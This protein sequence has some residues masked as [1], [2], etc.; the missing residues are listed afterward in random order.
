MDTAIQ[1]GHVPP[2][3]C[4]I[5][6]LP[7]SRRFDI[8]RKVVVDT[9]ESGEASKAAGGRLPA[10]M[11]QTLAKVAIVVALC[12]SCPPPALAAMAQ[13]PLAFNIPGGPLSN[14]LIEIGKRSGAIVSFSP[15]LVEGEAAAPVQ[16]DFTPMQAFMRALSASSLS[17]DVTPNGT[18]TV[19]PNQAAKPATKTTT[20]RPASAV[21]EIPPTEDPPQDPPRYT[22]D[23]VLVLASAGASHA[24]GLRASTAS[25]ATRTDTPLLELPQSV[26]V[27]TRDALDLHGPNVT[28]TDALRYVTGV[29][30]ESEGMVPSL[31]VRGLP[32]QY[33]LSGMGSLRGGLSIDSA[34]VERI[35]VLKGP[36]GVIGGVADFGGRGGIVNLVR[37]SI[38]TQ[39]YAE[40]KQGFTSRDGGTLRTDLEAAGEVAPRTYWRTVAYGSRSGHTDGGYASQQATG[41]LGLLGYRGADVNATLTLQTDNRRIAPE[42]ISRGGMQRADGSFTAIEPS[43][44]GAIDATDGMRWR[45]TDIELDLSWQLSPQWRMTWKGRRESLDSDM[46]QHLYWAFD[47]EAGVDLARHQTDARGASMQWG[48]I[49]NFATGPMSHRL[50]MAFDLDHW[51]SQIGDESASWDVDPATF[52]PGVTPLPATPTDDSSQ[53]TR[54][55]KRAVLLQDQVRLGNW[56]ARLAAQRG[57][58]SESTDFDG[59][60]L[61]EPKFTNWE[62][63]LLYQITPTVSVYAGTQYSV[64]VDVEGGDYLLYDGT[65]APLRKLRQTQ[66]GTKLELLERRLALTL[67][68]FRL[69]QLT[70]LKSSSELP[71]SGLFAL[72]GRSSTGVEAELSGR[73]SP[74][75][76]MHLGLNL[77]RARDAVPGPDSA[78][79]QSVESPAT[80]I[81][82][83]SLHLLARYR[84]PATEPVH[85]SVGLAF[86]AYSSSWVVP[87]DPS[88][89]PSGLRLPGG[90]QF[91]LS[92]TR[93]AER[94]A[95]RVSIKNLFDRQLYGTQST[96]GYIPLQPRRS[97]GLTATFMN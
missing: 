53:T 72:P 95:L 32:A 58:S 50:L 70:T 20:E 86:R 77:I 80:G 12:G 1:A 7:S 31:M 4:T 8:Q 73:V 3:V 35:E 97:V 42:P 89:G 48:L 51:R 66:A 26:S 56:I 10:P 44:V 21:Y 29:T 64:E 65:A 43:Q 45:S 5:D 82:E 9:H 68:A 93:E 76:D 16:G 27:V 78:P 54:K 17:I 94:L 6:A 28:T 55:R 90:A 84:L 67:E 75:L 71:D 13:E 38:E 69:R 11:H 88:G 18:V 2:E 47:D 14:A 52:E 49:G 25:T 22:L 60:P 96:P 33:L 79:L 57:H 85:H 61:Q 63:G 62:A 81:P 40:V 59:Y 87:P 39:P 34:F 74:A 23:P 37:K 24:E 15:R 46:R 41:L 83:R 92:W 91:D 19:Y 30:D 36:S